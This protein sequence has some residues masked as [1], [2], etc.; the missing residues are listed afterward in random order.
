M[1]SSLEFHSSV[2]RRCWA[3]A[4]TAESIRVWLVDR[5]CLVHWEGLT[6]MSGLHSTERAWREGWGLKT[7]DTQ[8]R[9]G[10]CHSR[11]VGLL[12]ARPA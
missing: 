8:P 9:G 7:K 3:P 2:Q 12:G 10:F 4:W 5:S 11:E 1:V 6:S